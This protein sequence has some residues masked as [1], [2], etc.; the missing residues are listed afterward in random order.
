MLMRLKKSNKSKKGYTLTELIV[1][2]AILGVLAAVATPLVIGQI[3]TARKNADAANA[4]TIE[5]IIRIA[6]A[7]GELVQIT[8][9][10]AYELVTSSIGELPVPQQGEDYTFYVNV[11]TAQVKCANTVP[12]DDA[13]EWV[14]IKENQGN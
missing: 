14:E 12:D 9:E 3:S 2:V 5:N 13:T 10:R 8:G 7:K 11:E 6:I 1:V 4:R